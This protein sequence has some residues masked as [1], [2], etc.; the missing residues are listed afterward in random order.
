MNEADLIGKV[1][2]MITAVNGTMTE[3]RNTI[4]RLCYVIIATVACFA[5]TIIFITAF[6]FFSSYQ[7]STTEVNQDVRQEVTQKTS[8]TTEGLSR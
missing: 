7:F 2:E 4:K 1:T 8:Q 6:Y 3:T 5:I